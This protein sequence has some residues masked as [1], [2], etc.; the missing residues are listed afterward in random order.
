M[1]TIRYEQAVYG[2]FPFWDRGYALLAASPGC[3]PEW[4]REFESICQRYGMPSGPPPFA[5]TGALFALRL[6]SRGGPW[7]VVLVAPQGADDRGRPGAL[8]F[9]GLFVTP[10]ELR[11]SLLGPFG[12]VGALRSEWAPGTQLHAGAWD[13]PPLPGETLPPEQEALREPIAAAL[14]LGRKVALESAEPITLLARAVWRADAAIPRKCSFATLAGSTAIP[15]DLV[16]LPRLA[17]DLADY[18]TPA[19]LPAFVTH[20]EPRIYL[21]LRPWFW[22]VIGAGVLLGAIWLASELR[23]P[24]RPEFAPATV[25]VKSA[26]PLPPPPPAPPRP[27]G[28]AVPEGPEERAAVAE[29]LRDLAARYGVPL[30]PPGSEPDD[31]AVLIRRVGDRLRYAG[32]SCFDGAFVRGELGP[33]ARRWKDVQSHVS[34]HFTSRRPWPA[35]VHA[36]PLRWQL[37]VLAWTLDVPVPPDLQAAEI[38]FHLAEALRVPAAPTP[39][40]P[41]LLARCPALAELSRFVADLPRRP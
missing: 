32:E 31:P 13:V 15:F 35:D 33:E 14:L 26:P 37:A 19:T 40:P 16:A 11:Q 7:L 34:Q 23:E 10:S 8:A 9:H 2:S 36:G 1:A 12:L 5:F 41:D 20:A 25:T 17:G 21:R 39:V 22:P 18:V 29:G 4:L 27:A 30:D 38:P 28:P 6:S 24:T 3:R